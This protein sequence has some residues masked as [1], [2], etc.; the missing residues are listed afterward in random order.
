MG[1]IT[2]RMLDELGYDPDAVPSALN[3]P[4]LRD[5]DRVPV[6]A[7]VAARDGQRAV[8]VARL[9][10]G[11]LVVVDDACPHDGG[12]ISDG[13]VEGEL[14]VCARHNWELTVDIDASQ[15]RRACKLRE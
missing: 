14:L 4:Q 13:F 1:A 6:G 10:S 8:A 3:R 11:R 15:C 5:V 7:M 12:L 2:V 9:H